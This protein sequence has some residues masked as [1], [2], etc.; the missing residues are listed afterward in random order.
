VEFEL[1]IPDLPPQRPAAGPG[2]SAVGSTRPLP[3][4]KA[5]PIA[6]PGSLGPDAGNAS[7]PERT[8][9]L[10]RSPQR[11]D[12]PNVRGSNWGPGAAFN[13]T[14]PLGAAGLTTG[15][16]QPPAPTAATLEPQVPAAS[17]PQHFEV[18]SLL[19][20]L[21]KT[22]SLRP[23]LL[24]DVTP[25]SLC[26]ETVGGY[27]DTLIA[28]NTPVPC[29][30]TRDFVTAHDNQQSVIVRVAQGESKQFQENVLLG[31][32]QLT[33]IPA[34][35]RGQ[36]RIAVTFGIDSD[37]ILH[38]RALDVVSGQSALANLRLQGAPTSPEVAQ[39]MAR[40]AAKGHA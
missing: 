24:I 34:A 16:W 36:S 28:R 3:A 6:D 20:S 25:L 27:V 33:G 14:L 22:P 10:P 18:P 8:V 19:A 12:S 32:V 21:P 31:E 23:A 38:V 15:A 29:E 4:P 9:P 26:V 7:S 11:A 1:P 39:M 40:H 30:R 17:Q 13:A 2:K 37:G 35:P 5:A